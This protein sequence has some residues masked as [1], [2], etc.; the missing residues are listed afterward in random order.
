MTA[1]DQDTIS[2]EDV[3]KDVSTF[4]HRGVTEFAA[5]IKTVEVKAKAEALEVIQSSTP[6]IKAAVTAALDHVEALILASMTLTKTTASTTPTQSA[7]HAP[8]SR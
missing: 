4:F 8:S 2:L 1:P 6:E 7:R 5:S 3:G